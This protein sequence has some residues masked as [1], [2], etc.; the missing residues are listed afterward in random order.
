MNAESPSIAGPRLL[1]RSFVESDL[2]TFYSWR[3]DTSDLHLWFHRAEVLSHREFVDDFSGFIRNYVHVLMMIQPRSSAQP[4]GVVYSYKSDYFN[5]HAYLCA[6]IDR[7]HR[8]TFIGAEATLLF[9]DYLF[10]YFP[11]RKLYGEVYG[12][13]A[14][15]L[16][17]LIK[18][19]WIEEGRLKNHIWRAGEYR[20]LLIFA[21]Y[22]EYF[23]NRYSS[24]LSNLKPARAG[25]QGPQI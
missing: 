2:E 16:N 5:G 7:A 17:N 14:E 12:H 24:M 22:R 19:G 11:F 8:G 15:S 18:G 6:F 13:N 21:M 3:C 20:D 23:Y 10:A 25:N 4:I 1:L 9:V